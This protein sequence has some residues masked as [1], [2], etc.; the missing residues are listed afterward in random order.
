M[1]A[2]EKITKQNASLDFPCFTKLLSAIFLLTPSPTIVNTVFDFENHAHFGQFWGWTF[3]PLLLI[4][5]KKIFCIIIAMQGKCGLNKHWREINGNQT[6]CLNEWKQPNSWYRRYLKR[7]VDNGKL[8]TYYTYN[9]KSIFLQK[10][11]IKL[12]DSPSHPW[13]KFSNNE[14]DEYA[15]VWRSWVCELL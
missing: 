15:N 10:C 12:F 6:L 9:C 7:I 11:K 2:D 3:W 1:E 14:S 8:N 4:W 13:I 5:K